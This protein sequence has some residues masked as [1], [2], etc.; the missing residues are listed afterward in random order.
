MLL[1]NYRRNYYPL[2]HAIKARHEER[3]MHTQISQIMG[4][5]EPEPWLPRWV[6]Q[7]LREA[8]NGLPPNDP[9]HDHKPPADAE[10]PLCKYDLDCQ[11]HMSLDHDTY[12]MRYW[13]CRLPTSPINW[14]W[15]DEKPRNVV[16]VLHLRCLLLIIS[17]LTI[18]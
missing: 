12:D 9:N 11:S 14:V 17:S 5:K 18:F 8:N 2:L 6:R 4:S 1:L 3:S 15:D 7:Q 13:S 16:S 10:R